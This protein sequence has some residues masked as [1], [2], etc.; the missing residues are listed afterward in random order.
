MDRLDLVLAILDSNGGKVD[1]RTVVQKLGYFTSKCTRLEDVHYRDFFYGPFSKAVALALEDLDDAML[2]YEMVR[3]SPIESYTYALTD[4]GRM[5]VREVKER[6]R[7]ECKIIDRIVSICRDRC[8]LQAHPLA[9]AAKSHY[10]MDHGRGGEDRS[11][12]G[13]EAMVRGFGWNLNG[14]DIRCGVGLLKALDLPSSGAVD[15]S[16]AARL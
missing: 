1:G 15:R 9:C 3:S 11:P 16:G 13:I 7:R 8:S 2:L 10:M 12:A 5:I 14:E 6:C 4:D